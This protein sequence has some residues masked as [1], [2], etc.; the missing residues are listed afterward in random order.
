M[1][2]NAHQ[3]GHRKHRS[4]DSN[5]VLFWPQPAWI[6]L[7]FQR[8]SQ[9]HPG[10]QFCHRNTGQFGYERDGPASSGV[11]F[12]YVNRG[13]LNV[14]LRRVWTSV[15]C[16]AVDDELHVHQAPHSEGQA[17]ASCVVDYGLNLSGAE[18]QA[19]VDG[20]GIAAVHPGTLNVFHD[21]RY[22]HLNAI[23]DGVNLTVFAFQIRVN[24]HR[25]VWGQ[26]NRGCEVLNQLS[27]VLDN[28][29]GTAT[30]DVAGA[31]HRWVANV[32]GHLQCL[33]NGSYGGTG[34]LGDTQP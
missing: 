28:L 8:L 23:T 24:E 14:I 25:F 9:H 30:D 6:P 1:P 20:H 15:G 11:Y 33:F 26:F 17:D 34:R 29:H 3:F 32:L 13:R 16:A 18:I 22:Q 21:S 19:G 7:V 5:Q 31:N 2:V 10:G 4:F 27:G 12:D